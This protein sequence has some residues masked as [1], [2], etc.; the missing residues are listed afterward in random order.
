MRAGRPPQAAPARAQWSEAADEHQGGDGEGRGSGADLDRRVGV[1]A[2]GAEH[3]AGDR[4]GE[5][6]RRPTA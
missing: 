2:V 6:G 5:D 4:D 1:E 3:L